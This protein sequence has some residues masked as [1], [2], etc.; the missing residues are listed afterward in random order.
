G[1]APLRQE[2]APTEARRKPAVSGAGHRRTAQPG[3]RWATRRPRFRTRRLDRL[4]RPLVGRPPRV[5][6]N[7]HRLDPPR[8]HYRPQE[9]QQSRI[10]LRRANSQVTRLRQ[11]I[12]VSVRRAAR[13]LLAAAQGVQAAERRRV[14]AAEQLRAETIRLEHGESTPFDVL[15]RDRDLVEAESQKI[16]ALRAYRISQAT[17]EREQGTILEDRNISIEQVRRLALD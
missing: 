10:E 2:P 8:Q 15:Q 12:I 17:L 13:G 7:G 9:R 11:D 3:G 6:R 4:P 14:A 1:A 16:E 5:Q